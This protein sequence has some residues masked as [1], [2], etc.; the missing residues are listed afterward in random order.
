MQYISVSLYRKIMNHA[1][2]EASPA[3]PLTICRYR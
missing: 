1:L 3:V 2:S